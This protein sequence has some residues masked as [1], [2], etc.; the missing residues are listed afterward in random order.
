MQTLSPEQLLE[1]AR[2]VAETFDTPDRWHKG[3]WGRDDDGYR[4]SFDGGFHVEDENGR[5]HTP[6]LR[7]R[8]PDAQR[9]FCLAGAIRIHTGAIAGC[10]PSSLGDLI[11]QICLV[12]VNLGKLHRHLQF[13][14]T[15]EPYLEAVIEWNDQ[16]ERTFPEIRSLARAVVDH[17]DAAR[18]RTG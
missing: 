16:S 10:N 15:F 18:F 12:Y 14:D 7:M 2:R 8:P 11:E 6:A 4:L 5:R 3:S 1:I 9:C 17:L 13:H